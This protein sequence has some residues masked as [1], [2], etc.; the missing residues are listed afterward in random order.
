MNLFLSIKLLIFRLVI[1][2]QK[3]LIS[4]IKI[5]LLLILFIQGY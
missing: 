5:L 1:R 2:K 4:K 3:S